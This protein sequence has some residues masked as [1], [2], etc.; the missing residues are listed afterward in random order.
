MALLKSTDQGIRRA[1][2]KTLGEIGTV[3]AVASLLPLSQ[4][5]LG[6]A[7]VRTA[8]LGAI[9]AIQARQSGAGAG[10]L[11]LND[12]AVAE[13]G[14]LDLVTTG[15]ELAIASEAGSVTLSAA[16]S[17]ASEPPRPQAKKTTA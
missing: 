5:V 14:R 12:T 15:G 2:T 13:E 4:G 10:Q 6:D 9:R 16:E 17:S 1:A 11:T 7:E 8:A 3:A